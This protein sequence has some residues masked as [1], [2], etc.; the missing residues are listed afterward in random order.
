MTFVPELQHP[1]VL[2]KMTTHQDG[3]LSL[4]VRLATTSVPP[5]PVVGRSGWDV[6]SHPR[7]AEPSRTYRIDFLSTLSYNVGREHC[8][9][10][11]ANADGEGRQFARFRKSAYLDFLEKACYSSDVTGGARYHYGIYCL[12]TVIDV[13][14]GEAPL[15]SYV[16]ETAA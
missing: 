12:D 1:L 8:F 3:S 16:G 9:A 7:V 4:L 14:S 6:M 2:V 15:I 11:D 13:V 10:A 5:A